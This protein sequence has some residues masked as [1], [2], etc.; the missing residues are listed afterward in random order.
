MQDLAGTHR[1][2]EWGDTYYQFSER[3]ALANSEGRRTLPR[4]EAYREKV[5]EGFKG[6]RGTPPVPLLKPS[7]RHDISRFKFGNK[8]RRGER[9]T[10]IA[11]W[12]D[13]QADL[14]AINA[15]KGLVDIGT[16]RVW[17]NGRLW[18]YHTD[19]GTGYPVEGDGFI[20]MTQAQYAALRKIA[21]YNGIN[22]RS[23]QELR[24]NPQFTDE[25][26]ELAY[27]VWRI[28]EGNNQ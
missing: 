15:G 21:S 19:T 10:M 28:R 24:S 20:P 16:G 5:P 23:E 3:K 13:V 9:N 27:R 7:D 1:S 25:D 6:I 14:D 2:A 22:K 17:I 26:I 8:G 4:T 11:P 18:G 12:V